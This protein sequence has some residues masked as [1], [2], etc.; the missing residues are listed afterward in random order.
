V[1]IETIKF[2]GDGLMMMKAMLLEIFDDF[3]ELRKYKKL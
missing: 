1:K 2:G 3:T